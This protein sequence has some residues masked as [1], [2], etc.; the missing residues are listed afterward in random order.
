VQPFADGQTYFVKDQPQSSS[1]SAMID[2]MAVFG[3]WS[4]T[5]ELPAIYVVERFVE[6]NGATLPSRTDKIHRLPRD[7]GITST[8]VP[9]TWLGRV[10]DV[11]TGI[12]GPNDPLVNI[13]WH[14]E[15]WLGTNR[16]VEPVGIFGGKFRMTKV[17]P[18]YQ[19][20]PLTDH[21]FRGRVIHEPMQ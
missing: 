16:I 13:V 12:W 8:P 3:R 1:K 11:M 20:I 19:G 21:G 9:G 10:P 4:D 5:L 15:Y 7:A 6:G 2:E 18:T 14:Q 17:V